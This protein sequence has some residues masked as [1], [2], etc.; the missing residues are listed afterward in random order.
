MIVNIEDNFQ[1]RN[2]ATFVVFYKYFILLVIKI[3]VI[4]DNYHDNMNYQD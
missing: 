2:I 4:V 3:I 1:Y